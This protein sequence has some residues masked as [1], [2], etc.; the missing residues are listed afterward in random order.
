[1]NGTGFIF[2]KMELVL[3]LTQI[4]TGSNLAGLEKV[5]RSST[6]SIKG[7]RRENGV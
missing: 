2:K 1:M 4:G 6:I 7:E 5:Q 3:F